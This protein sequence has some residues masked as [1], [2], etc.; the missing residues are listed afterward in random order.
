MS[1]QYVLCP[2]EPQVPNLLSS[3]PSHRGQPMVGLRGC[4]GLVLKEMQVALSPSYLGHPEQRSQAQ[5]L[6]LNPVSTETDISHRQSPSFQIQVSSKTCSHM[7]HRL[8]NCQAIGDLDSVPPSTGY[9]EGNGGYITASWL[10]VQCSSLA[11]PK[12]GGPAAILPISQGLS[13]SIH[14]YSEEKVPEVSTCSLS[15]SDNA[16]SMPGSPEQWVQGWWDWE[17][18][19]STSHN[20]QGSHSKADVAGTQDVLPGH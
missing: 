12:P 17:F 11:A 9:E 2:W 1:A 10:P 19:S 5:P 6:I 20:L 18:D 4:Q 13:M 16:R 3:P 15:T 7:T 8:H 14:P